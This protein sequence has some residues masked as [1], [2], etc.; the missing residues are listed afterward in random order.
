[1]VPCPLFYQRSHVTENRCKAILLWLHLH[2]LCQANSSNSAFA[3]CK[4]LVSK[5]SVNQL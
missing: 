2:F 5:P 1:M 3:S 4:S